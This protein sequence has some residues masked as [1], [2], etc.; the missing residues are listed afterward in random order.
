MW[1]LLSIITAVG[2]FISVLLYWSKRKQL[3]EDD[4]YYLYGDS[5]YQELTDEKPVTG[6]KN[7]SIHSEI[8][9]GPDDVSN[10]VN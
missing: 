3:I 9:E 8:I 1:R 7:N 10:L 4:Q 6:N 2:S 5:L